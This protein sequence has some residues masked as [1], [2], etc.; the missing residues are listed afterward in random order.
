MIIIYN[1]Q[2]KVWRIHTRLRRGLRPLWRDFFLSIRRALCHLLHRSE[3]GEGLNVPW[4]SLLPGPSPALLDSRP[5]TFYLS[6]VLFHLLQ[7][8]LH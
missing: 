5:G 8:V 3:P 1:A 7:T 2:K 6:F 4:I